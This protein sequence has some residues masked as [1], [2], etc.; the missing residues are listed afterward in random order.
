VGLG[1]VGVHDRALGPINQFSLADFAVKVI[2]DFI[3]NDL[4]GD[5]HGLLRSKKRANRNVLIDIFPM[6]SD[7]P[8]DE[9]PIG[10]LL[11]CCAKEPWKPRQRRRNAPSV[12]ESDDQFVVGALNV[13]SVCDGFTGQSAHPKQR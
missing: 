11:G 6:N 9:P 3:G 13:D 7:S 1:E 5:F 12:H 2:G 4:A 8:A 10:A